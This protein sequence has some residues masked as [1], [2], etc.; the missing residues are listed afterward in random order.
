MSLLETNTQGVESA[1]ATAIITYNMWYVY[2]FHDLL[3]GA[4]LTRLAVL[5]LETQL[6][7]TKEYYQDKL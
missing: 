6:R 2:S 7:E 3:F 1:A 4:P 5:Q